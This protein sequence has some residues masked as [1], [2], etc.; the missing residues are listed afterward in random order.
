MIGVICRRDILAHPIVT[1]Q[2]FGWRVFFR[3]I[4]ADHHQTFLSL[5]ADSGALRPRKARVPGLVDR[6]IQ[7][8]RR[9]QRIY[10]RLAGRFVGHQA[11][12]RFLDTLARQEQDHAEMLELCREA[13]RR[14]VWREECFSPWREVIPQ[15]ECR[16]DDV[17][18]SLDSLDDVPGTLRL[19]LEIEGSEVNR[20]FEGVVEASGSRFV[21]KVRAFH[22]AVAEHIAYICAEIPQLEPELHADC[23]ELAGRHRLVTAG[24]R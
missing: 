6:C 14:S 23:H 19:V 11:V 3:A 13:A 1:I 12:C 10:Q 15:L 20:V 7:L 8:E 9:A 17:E 22:S 16:M 24:L 21:R 2:C 4:A 18:A 5:L